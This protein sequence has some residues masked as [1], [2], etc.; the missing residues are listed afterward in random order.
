MNSSPRAFY[1]WYVVAATFVLLWMGFGAAYS[2][3]A[4]F[5]SLRD[6]FEATRGDTSL[7]FGIAGFLYFGL[8]ALT[9]PLADRIGPRPVVMV[10]VVLAG[11]G[12]VLASRAQSLW[13]VYLTYSLGVG[14]GVGFI[15]VPAVGAIQR[16]FVRKRGSASGIAVS[17]IGV[18]TL[19]TPLLANF[20]ID[21]GGWRGAYLT[22]G[23]ATLAVGLPAAF[24]LERS[25]AGRNLLPDGDAVGV[26]TSNLATALG[27]TL[28]EALRSR[29]FWLLYGATLTT[30]LGLFIPFVHLA[31]F[32]KDHGVS[33]R[34]AT[35]LIGMIGVGSIVGRLAMGPAADRL[36][37][38][39]ALGTTFAV[40]AGA[41]CLWLVSSQYSLLVVFSLIFGAAYG[42][43]VALIP[44]LT[45]DYFGGRSVGAILGVLYT[46][47]AFGALV[48]PPF[49]GAVFDIRES[50]AFPIA[51]GAAM[52]CIATV[53]VIRLRP[54][55]NA[56]LKEST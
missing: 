39:A 50:Y 44:A 54:P 43:F 33:A 1:G 14:M 4:F 36:G 22:L 48:G 27:F 13:Q 30:G 41:F 6:E 25:P 5:P 9:G 2:F 38:K 23:I 26:Q 15:Y 42:G 12:L 31:P 52:N 21:Q 53:C 17:G 24:L 35:L 19:V 37:R 20:L 18:G 45:A 34:E 40:M 8:G 10:G 7:V 11:A 55:S 28:T 56:R 49:A 51:F 29:T 32:A 46:G 47:A 3:A 16:W